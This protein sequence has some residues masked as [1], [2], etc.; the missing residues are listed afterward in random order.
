MSDDKK[1]YHK[2]PDGE[3][4]VRIEKIPPGEGQGKKSGPGDEASRHGSLPP[5]RLAHDIYP[6]PDEPFLY[7]YDLGTELL[8]AGQASYI[9]NKALLDMTFRINPNL[10]VLDVTYSNEDYKAW[11]DSLLGSLLGEGHEEEVSPTG[12]TPIESS[13]RKRRASNVWPWSWYAMGGAPPPIGILRKAGAPSTPYALIL[14]NWKQQTITDESWAAINTEHGM[15]PNWGYWNVPHNDRYEHLILSDARWQSFQ[16]NDLTHYKV[17]REPNFAAEVVGFKMEWPLKIYAVPRLIQIDE[18]RGWRFDFGSGAQYTKREIY[19]RGMMDTGIG[20]RP[21]YWIRTTSESSMI[22]AFITVNF[23]NEA[24]VHALTRTPLM[25]D[26]QTFGS[27]SHTPTAQAVLTQMPSS[28]YKT[29]RRYIFTLRHVKT[30]T[31]ERVIEGIGVSPRHESLFGPTT[32]TVRNYPNISEDESFFG[33]LFVGRRPLSE[34]ELKA[35]AQDLVKSEISADMGQP[36]DSIGGSVHTA[37][38]S[39]DGTASLLMAYNDSPPAYDTFGFQ[40]R[41]G[42]LAA[43]ILCGKKRFYVWRK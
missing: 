40:T 3:V 43:L 13:P 19:E 18:G 15:A 36:F 11:Q 35:I 22:D 27:V 41:V 8:P 5:P 24:S 37:D 42:Q 34:L 20:P 31:V 17:T 4:V 28:A 29:S 26:P 14:K 9:E 1:D 30:V 10:G 21:Y 38:Y 23:F 16:T 12:L 7:F 25:P 32:R 39:Y 6:P 2:G 33:E